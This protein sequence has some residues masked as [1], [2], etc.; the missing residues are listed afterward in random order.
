MF[1]AN[2]KM[3]NQLID[4]TVRDEAL[5]SLIHSRRESAGENDVHYLGV[6]TVVKTTTGLETI[7]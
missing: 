7:L 3:D 2:A 5:G 1:A 4:K 6:G